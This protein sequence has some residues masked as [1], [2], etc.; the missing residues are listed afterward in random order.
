MSFNKRSR[1]Y[2]SYL[3]TIRYTFNDLIKYN[4]TIFRTEYKKMKSYSRINQNKTLNNFHKYVIK[5]KFNSLTLPKLNLEENNNLY[6]ITSS[7]F[8]LTKTENDKK[9]Y[10]TTTNFTDKTNKES[11]KINNLKKVSIP[12]IK[13]FE[14]IYYKKPLSFNKILSD[15]LKNFGGKRYNDKFISQFSERTKVTRKLNINKQTLSTRLKIFK[16]N[17]QTE[18][19][20]LERKQFIFQEAKRKL[21]LFTDFLGQYVLYLYGIINKERLILNELFNTQSDLQLITIGLKN[22]ITKNQIKLELYKQYKIFLLLVKYKKTKLIDIPEIELKKYGIELEKEESKP[23]ILPRK[24]AKR[25]SNF[26]NPL[27]RRGSTFDSTKNLFKKNTPKNSITRKT[28]VRR[29]SKFDTMG[30]IFGSKSSIPLNFNIPIFESVDEFIEK[31]NFLENTV[32]ELFNIFSDHQFYSIELL[33]EKDNESYKEKALEKLNQEIMYNSMTE[34]NSL[35]EKNL[36]LRNK[37]NQIMKNYEVVINEKLYN[38]IKKILISL[39]INI[40]I[41]FNIINFYTKINNVNNSTDVIMIKGKKYNKYLYCLSV[42]ERIMIH[43]LSLIRKS[44]FLNPKTQTLFYTISNDID[45]K[46][47]FENN[48]NRIMKQRRR[49][50]EIGEKVLEKNKKI[51]IPMKKKYDIYE[52]LI[53]KRKKEKEE[54]KYGKNNNKESINIY[55]NWIIYK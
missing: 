50:E 3:G 4:P 49:I 12:K 52:D 5:K 31:F 32:R 24:S 21:E 8:F 15:C 29:K 45:R 38:K 28:I 26:K 34:L 40:E 54:K 25:M 30:F 44:T 7:D 19:R 22:K 43:Y 36:I 51:I 11:K 47:R 46:K 10:Q 18:I 53:I 23:N 37:Y 6:T 16:E 1:N 42:L 39:P 13:N 27:S 9:F 41:D 17:R 20:D 33:K 55:E 35:K 48:K 2:S 14:T